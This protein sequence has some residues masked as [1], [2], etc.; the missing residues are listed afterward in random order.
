MTDKHFFA[1]CDRYEEN[2]D[3]FSRSGLQQLLSAAIDRVRKLEAERNQM[4]M[5]D[6]G[7]CFMSLSL[8][9]EEFRTLQ[10]ALDRFS[11]DDRRTPDQQ[12]VAMAKHWMDVVT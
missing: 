5:N 1:A 9:V 4:R 11:V 7:R 8:T 2:S 10:A 3:G 6:E 12:I